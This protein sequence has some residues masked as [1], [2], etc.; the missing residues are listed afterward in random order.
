MKSAEDDVN[1]SGAYAREAARWGREADHLNFSTEI[2]Y[3]LGHLDE[4][5]INLVE[6]WPVNAQ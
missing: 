3:T 6:Q 2:Q 5:Y 4:I 1:L